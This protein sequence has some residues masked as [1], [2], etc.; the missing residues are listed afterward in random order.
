M[1]GHVGRVAVVWR[2]DRNARQT[3]NHDRLRPVFDAL[4]DVGIVAEPVVYNDQT[5]AAARDRLLRV[6]GVLVW[7]DPIGGGEDRA[8]LDAALREVSLRGVWVSAH[9]DTIQKMGTKEVLYRTKSMSWGTDTHRYATASEFREQFPERM[10]AGQPRVL[11][12]NRGNG[13][14]GVWK[15]TLLDGATAATSSPIPPEQ[16]I[17]RVQH[18][19]PRDDV[20]EDMTLESFMDRCDQYFAGSAPLL[21][22]AFMSRLGAG[23]IRAYLVQDEVVGFARQQ[24]AMPSDARDAADKVLG[25]PAAKTMYP[26]SEPTFAAL[27]HTLEQEWV[28]GL[29]LLVDID[30]DELPLVWDADFLYGPPTETATDTYILCEINVSSV[31]PFPDQVPTKLAHAVANRLTRHG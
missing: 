23:M 14:I 28:P 17:V 29:R 13:G 26:A 27:K 8:K 4:V 9:P 19:A 25:M 1:R 24:P 11:K 20:T 7:V 6:D 21:D 30:D 2:G 15:V 18:A 5:L 3:R 16:I 12:Q 31:L 10:R 22:Q